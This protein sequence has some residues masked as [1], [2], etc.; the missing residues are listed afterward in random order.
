MG[1]D[2]RLWKLPGGRDWLWVKLGLALV[3][4]AMLSKSLIQFS[5]DEWG[6]VPSLRPNYGR[7]NGKLLQKNLGQD[8]CIQCP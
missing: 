8:C 3:D 1:E 4:K 5:A 7:G 6:C 2:K